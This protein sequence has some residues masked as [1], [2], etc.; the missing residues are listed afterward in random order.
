[1][2]APILLG[3][4]VD[5][6]IV[7][8]FGDW[9]G[10]YQH[11]GIDYATPP[12]SPVYFTGLAPAVVNTPT[13]DGSFGIAVGVDYGTGLYGIYAHLLVRYVAPG[14]VVAPGTVIGLTGAT[15]MVT[16]PHL[17][18]QICDS[19]AFPVDLTRSRDPEALMLTNLRAEGCMDLIK[20]LD[21][22]EALLAGNGLQ[23][24]CRPGTAHLFPPGTPVVPEGEDGPLHFLTGEAALAY[25][26]ARG[27]S[28]ALGL[29]ITQDR[30]GAHL[31]A[32]GMR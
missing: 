9:Y 27:F 19:P 14:E 7:G 22:L 31:D 24:I 6:P 23:A 8:G 10:S 18:F 30:L 4:P 13:N 29:G 21:R 25:A 11:R 16:G 1:M 26:A 5:A 17:H 15:G 20:R 28:F 32:G 2:S 3:H 12:G